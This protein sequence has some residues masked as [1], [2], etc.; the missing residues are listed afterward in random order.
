[1][2][3]DLVCVETKL[4]PNDQWY[5]PGIFVVVFKPTPGHATWLHMAEIEC[6]C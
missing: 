6:S 3:N 4:R 2:L 1:M 5:F